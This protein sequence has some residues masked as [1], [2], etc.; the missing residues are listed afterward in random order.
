MCVAAVAIRL[1]EDFP[2]VLVH[3]RD[4]Y[5][6]R[7]SRGL[8]LRG[9]VAGGRDEQAG[10]MWLGVR[11]ER[12]PRFAFVTNLRSGPPLREPAKRSRGDLVKNFLD[13]ETN[14][15]N[16]LQTLTAADYG[17]FNLVLG[18]FE[19]YQI[20][21]SEKAS[22]LSLSTGVHTVSNGDP[23]VVWPK[24]QRLR[25]AVSAILPRAREEEGLVKV[26]M[27]V[28]AD[29][30]K[31]PDETLPKTGVS[32]EWERELSSIWVQTKDY[33]TVASTVILQNK[34]GAVR[35]WERTRNKKGRFETSQVNL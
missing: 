14:G 33:G 22:T 5:Y 13:G 12:I 24:S 2:F 1:S 16:Y 31:A 28:L 3:N 19:Q 26:L 21:H 9:Q 34:T 11:K 29:D 6:R 10:G 8:E 4:E 15:E 23:Q 25:E 27:Q 30:H 17:P 20:F 18:S 32:L 35:L 7:P